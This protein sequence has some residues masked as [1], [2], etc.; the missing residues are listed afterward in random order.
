MRYSTSTQGAHTT[1]RLSGFRLLRSVPFSLTVYKG[2]CGGGA[3]RGTDTL[4]NARPP[5][6]GRRPRDMRDESGRLCLDAPR[7]QQCPRARPRMVARRPSPETPP[8]GYGTVT[9]PR[10]R[11]HTLPADLWR[12]RVQPRDDARRLRHG[13]S[14]AAAFSH[15][16]CR[17]MA[18]EGAASGSQRVGIG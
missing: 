11:S 18:V 3:Q 16:S 13:D 8:T 1:L 5:P 10:P 15:P 17:S 6:L 9:T 4:M 12:L 14:A 2:R 7:Q